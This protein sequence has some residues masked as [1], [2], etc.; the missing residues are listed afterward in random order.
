MWAQPMG[1]PTHAHQQ[2]PMM[3]AQQPGGFAR[4]PQVCV[5]GC[6]GIGTL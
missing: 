4:A 3:Y 1:P 2:A 6:V 5:C